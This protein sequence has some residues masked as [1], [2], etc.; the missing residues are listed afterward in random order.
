LSL[1]VFVHVFIFSLSFKHGKEKIEASKE[2][3]DQLKNWAIENTKSI[4]EKYDEGSAF[5]TEYLSKKLEIQKEFL[6]LEEIKR[7]NQAIKISDFVDKTP[8]DQQ[9]LSPWIFEKTINVL[10]YWNPF[11]TDYKTCASAWALLLVTGFIIL[12][13]SKSNSISWNEIKS[14]NEDIKTNAECINK[15]SDFTHKSIIVL[16]NGLKAQD[17]KIETLKRNT[18][19]VLKETGN[20]LNSYQTMLNNLSKITT[21]NQELNY[22]M[23]AKIRETQRKINA[24]LGDPEI[25]PNWAE[26]SPPLFSVWPPGQRYV[27]LTSIL[28]KYENKSISMTTVQEMLKEIIKNI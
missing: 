1:Q 19:A 13:I 14:I 22:I 23:L 6:Q 12:A 28:K 25:P 11:V 20:Q 15:Q 9:G 7:H 24:I 26:A 2:I 10:N 16:T 8:K 21:L 27:L 5:A 17:V 3:K 18:D 4:L